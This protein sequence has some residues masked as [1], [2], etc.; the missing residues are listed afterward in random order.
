MDPEESSTILAQLESEDKVAAN[1]SISNLNTVRQT[2]E[3]SEKM[4]RSHVLEAEPS[5]R[6][7]TAQMIGSLDNP[8]SEFKTPME[9]WLAQTESVDVDSAIDSSIPV[10]DATQENKENSEIE[11]FR[12]IHITQDG[13]D[14]DINHGEKSVVDGKWRTNIDEA[15]YHRNICD[16][17][18]CIPSYLAHRLAQ[19]NVE[20]ARRLP[21]AYHAGILSSNGNENEN[22]EQHSS[23]DNQSYQPALP[24]S[25][26]DKDQTLED[27]AHKQSQSSKYDSDTSLDPERYG[28]PRITNSIC[29]SFIAAPN[30]LNRKKSPDY[31][32]Y[33]SQEDSSNLEMRSFWSGKR[34]RRSSISSLSRSSNSNDSMQLPDSIFEYLEEKSFKT[35]SS[36]SNVDSNKPGFVIPPPPVELGKQNTFICDVCGGKVVVL[37]RRD[38]Q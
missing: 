12:R 8:T 10:S 17:F 28:Q 37:R 29:S 31:V 35:Q 33:P 15:I 2:T 26:G 3:H 7:P 18:P 27:D 1:T 16:R 19:A 24:S 9:L 21:R 4:Q 32:S 20:R 36:T 34:Q 23:G 13:N 30:A 14:L 25:H 22:L 11:Y 6:K 38:W 5:S